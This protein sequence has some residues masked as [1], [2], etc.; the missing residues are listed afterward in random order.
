M[1]EKEKDNDKE[2]TFLPQLQIPEGLPKESWS[3]LWLLVETI[4]VEEI[5]CKNGGG[6]TNFLK[7]F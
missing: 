6:K 5:D 3:R 2:T 4:A 7:G 1:T